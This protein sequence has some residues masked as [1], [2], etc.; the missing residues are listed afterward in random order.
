MLRRALYRWIHS[1]PNDTQLAVVVGGA[2]PAQVELISFNSF[3]SNFNSIK[4]KF[5]ENI[6]DR[7]CPGRV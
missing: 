4:I 3:K 6:D 1:I 2:E 7:C 5:V